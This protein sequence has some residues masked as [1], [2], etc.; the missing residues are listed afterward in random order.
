MSETEVKQE[1]R[2]DKADLL[3]S[4][5]YKNKADYI[6]ALLKDGKTYTLKEVEAAITKYEKG[7]VS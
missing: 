2:Y 5:K 7:K 6:E 1:K 3:L 4:E